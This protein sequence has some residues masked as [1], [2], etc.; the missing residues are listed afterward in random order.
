MRSGQAQGLCEVPP[1]AML[2]VSHDCAQVHV[3]VH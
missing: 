1:G 2:A 3:M